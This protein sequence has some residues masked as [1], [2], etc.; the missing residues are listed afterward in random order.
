MAFPGLSLVL[1]PYLNRMPLG[2]TLCFTPQNYGWG[3][4]ARDC[5]KS[6]W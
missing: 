2:G 1:P 5:E 4:G 3:K 6:R